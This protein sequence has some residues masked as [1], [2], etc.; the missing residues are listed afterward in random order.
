MQQIIICLS[1][2]PDTESRRIP[3]GQIAWLTDV[4]S[5]HRPQCRLYRRAEEAPERP[6]EMGGRTAWRHPGGPELLRYVAASAVQGDATECQTGRHQLRPQQSVEG[7]SQSGNP[8][9]GRS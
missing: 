8:D 6:P 3:P 5:G 9:D 2:F 1:I 7:R 4:E